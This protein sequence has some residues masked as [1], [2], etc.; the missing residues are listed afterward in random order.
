MKSTLG[1]ELP[2]RARN[3]DAGYDFFLPEDLE[4][5]RARPETIDTGII[6]EEGDIPEGAVMLLLPRSSYGSKYGLHLVNTCG[7][8]DSGY[9]GTIKARMEIMDPD[10]FFLKL[11]KGDRFMQGIIVPFLT[12]DGEIPPE[13][14]RGEGGF[15]STGQ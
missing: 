9:R 7:V 6:M 12:I 11:K 14:D 15:G 2:R 1:A 13:E 10:T 4:L 3:G 8:I 5:Y